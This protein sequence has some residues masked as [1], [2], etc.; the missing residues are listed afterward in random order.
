MPYSKFLGILKFE[1]LKN[2]D[3]S[4]SKHN[5]ACCGLFFIKGIFK[6]VKINILP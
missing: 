1:V 5:I 3:R 6:H 4:N 2:F